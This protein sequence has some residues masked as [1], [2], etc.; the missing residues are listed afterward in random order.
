ME[1]DD[2]SRSL[3]AEPMTPV[4]AAPG[5][6]GQ[7]LADRGERKPPR[8]KAPPE[9]ASEAAQE[10]AADAAEEDAIEESDLP[11]HRIDDIA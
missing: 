6:Q 9:E 8:R 3:P 10:V 4:A 11:R 1:I 2:L 5:A 7:A